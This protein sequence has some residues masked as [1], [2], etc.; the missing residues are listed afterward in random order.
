[1]ASK[2]QE[3]SRAGGTRRDWWMGCD[4]TSLVADAQDARGE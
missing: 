3:P 1:M 4:K 2:T